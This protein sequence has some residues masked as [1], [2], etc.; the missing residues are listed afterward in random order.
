MLNILCFIAIVE[1]VKTV[2]N[3][4]YPAAVPEVP[5][6]VYG[7]R[8]QSINQKNYDILLLKTLFDIFFFTAIVETKIVVDAPYPAAVPEVPAAVYGPRKK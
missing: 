6:T 1:L 2:I 4:P 5:A 3:S 7:P 8:K